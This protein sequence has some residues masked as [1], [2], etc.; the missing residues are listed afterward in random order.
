[1]SHNGIFQLFFHN[2]QLLWQY[3][4]QTSKIQPG[5]QEDY[6]P[7]GIT[8]YISQFQWSPG[9]DLQ[10]NCEH[11]LLYYVYEQ[12]SILFPQ[13]TTLICQILQASQVYLTLIAHL[14]NV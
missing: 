3:H 10:V 4:R 2:T 8:P 5:N 1:M 6:I 14:V 11:S 7:P 9:P 13:V 12:Y